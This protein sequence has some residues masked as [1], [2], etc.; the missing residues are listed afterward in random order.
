MRAEGGTASDVARPADAAKPCDGSRAQARLDEARLRQQAIGVRLRQMF[1]QV[2][3]EPIP[4]EFLDI[5]RR[6][7]EA[8]SGA[9]ERLSARPRTAAPTRSWTGRFKRELVALIPHLRAFART[10]TRR[11]GQRRRPGAGRADEGMGRPR[12]LPDGHEHEGLDLH[13]PAQPVLFGEAQIAGAR[14]SWTRKPPSA[15][16]SPSTIRSR[17]SLWTRCALRWRCCRPNSARP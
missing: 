2:V 8:L 16:W 17:R 1:D 4:Q 5:L 6:G 14:P 10:L 12:Q 15:R 13:D 9:D 3:N 7:D 11:P